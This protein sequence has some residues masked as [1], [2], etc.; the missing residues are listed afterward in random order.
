MQFGI[1]EIS[2]IPVRKEASERSEMVTQVLFG[3]LFS[4]VEH[5]NNWSY[6]QLINDKYEGWI[7]KE[8][9]TYIDNKNAKILQS[10]KPFI[11]S[12]F[13]ANIQNCANKQ[14]TQISFG[15]ELHQFNPNQK[16]FTIGNNKYILLSDMEINNIK[17]IEKATNL[18]LN[19]PYLWGGKNPLGI[20]CSG[21]TQLIYKAFGHSI[22]RDAKD[23]VTLGTTVSFISDTKAGDLAFFDNEM[24]NITHVGIILD[25]GQIIHSSL[26]VRIDK[27]DQQGIFNADLNKYTHNL[28]TIK[29]LLNK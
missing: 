10:Q 25:R 8:Y 11:I 18:F 19:A 23:Q 20:D 29:R 17:S 9:I 21:F 13:M 22:P 1:S 14:I 6:I 26:K 4:I 27:I 24:G 28:R 16:T 7:S 3:E 12:D 2:V 5:Q 15:A